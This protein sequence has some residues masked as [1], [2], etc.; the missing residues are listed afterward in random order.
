MIGG[1]Y[2]VVTG[3]VRSDW[4]PSLEWAIAM[5]EDD[6]DDDS[7]RIIDAS[8]RVVW[9]NGVAVRLGMAVEA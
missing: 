4:V 7:V 8:A 5:A 1:Y 6:Y 3:R 9:A 2:R